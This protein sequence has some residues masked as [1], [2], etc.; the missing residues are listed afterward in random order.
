MAGRRDTIAASQ[1]P[2][3]CERGRGD[4]PRRRLGQTFDRYGP[5]S[6]RPVRDA[7]FAA[8]GCPSSCSRPVL[9]AFNLDSVPFA[10]VALGRQAVD[11]CSYDFLRGN[12]LTPMVAPAAVWMPSSFGEEVICRRFLTNLVTDM[13][14]GGCGTWG[15]AVGLK[16]PATARSG[17]EERVTEIQGRDDLRA[18][19]RAIVLPQRNH[20]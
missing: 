5:R 3:R 9:A 19:S 12:L 13:G 20:P 1:S 2:P 11:R 16:A 7:S 18:I 10:N 15:V 14:G 4:S 17:T 6:V 8:L